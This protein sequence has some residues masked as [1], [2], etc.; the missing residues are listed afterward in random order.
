M[1]IRGVVKWF[2]NEKGFGFLAQPEGA[3]VFV[4]FSAINVSGYR[5][6]EEGEQVEF[7]VE[8]GPKG[9]M[10]V[11]VAPVTESPIRGGPSTSTDDQGAPVRS[12]HV[13]PAGPPP[14]RPS[15]LSRTTAPRKALK[16]FLCHSSTDKTEVRALYQRLLDEDYIEAWFDEEV[17]LPGQNWEYEIRKAVRT[18][19]VVIVCLSKSSVTR[20]GYVQR[21]ISFALDV[22]QDLPE[23]E[24]FIVPLRINE[25]IVPDRL[26]GWHWVDYYSSLGHDRL[27]KALKFR[28]DSLL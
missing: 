4:H 27:L 10:A 16:V 6:L 12:E 23:G 21:E 20:R 14:I 5:G 13:P 18:S 2:N 9:L 22:A 26:S 1:R 3:D 19:D 15:T 8:Q 11:N 7:E 28:W 25:C 24:I 17:L